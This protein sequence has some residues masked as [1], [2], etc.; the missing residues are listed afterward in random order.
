MKLLILLACLL[1]VV[2]TVPVRERHPTRVT[3]KA[4][5]D[6]HSVRSGRRVE[7]SASGS[8]EQRMPRF[9][10]P[11]P[12]PPPP[13]PPPI[14]LLPPPIPLLPPPPILPPLPLPEAPAPPNLPPLP[15]P[16]I[17]I[18]IPIDPAQA[19]GAAMPIPPF[20]V[21]GPA[22][23]FPGFPGVP[24][25]PPIIGV[26]SLCYTYIKLT[27]LSSLHRVRKADI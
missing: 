27:Y 21:P 22:P 5:A 13:P 24:G 2:L 4:E 14:P 26:S 8:S 18:P 23:F 20:L 1:N 10:I 19:N 9:L 6:H 12:P 17:P 3:K 11:L 16:L 15:I 25:F 7:R